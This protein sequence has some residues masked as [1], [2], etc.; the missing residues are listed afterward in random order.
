MK[1]TAVIILT[2]II[3]LLSGCSDELEGHTSVSSR[4]MTMLEHH[5]IPST[6]YPEDITI[7]SI[8]DSLTE[9]VGD[10]KDQGGYIPYLDSQLEELRSIGDVTFH[11]LGKKGR[12]TSSM[13]K[14]LDDQ[15]YIE[16][17]SQSQ[18]IIVTVGGNDMMKVLERNFQNLSVAVFQREIDLYK[19]N[20][21]KNIVRLREINP[22]AGIVLVGIYNPFLSFITNIQEVDEVL[23][24]WNKAS[25]DVIS[26]YDKTLFVDISE[27][28]IENGEESILAED[29]FHP[30][31][32]G[33]ERMANQLFLALNEQEKW[34]E[35]AIFP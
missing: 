11:N 10:S 31:D 5:A 33:Y 2:S 13:L 30:N 16:T 34:K 24:L 32:V 7:A 26:Q 1:S 25:E 15:E 35:L 12:T 29:Y 19:N 23:T 9:G 18:L 14:K 20:L 28:F 17:L 6:F 3:L 4:S 27:L 8:G 22:D 21:E